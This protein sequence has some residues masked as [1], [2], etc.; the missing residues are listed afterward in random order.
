VA[1]CL[2]LGV[3]SLALLAVRGAV[4]QKQGRQRHDSN[5]TYTAATILGGSG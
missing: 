5:A 1:A 3:L 2:D 4:V